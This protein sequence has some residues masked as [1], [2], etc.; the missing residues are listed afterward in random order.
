LAN[1]ALSQI[2]EDGRLMEWSLPFKEAEPG[3][4]HLS[5]LF[6]FHP[7][8]QYNLHDSP[9]MASAVRKS[10]D[11]RLLHGGGHTGWSRA[12]IISFWARLHEP[13]DAYESLLIL[14][15]K[16]TISN[17][18]NT[19]PPFQIDGNFG[20]V[21]GIAEMLVQSHVGESENGYRIQLLPA[22]PSAWQKG[23]VK[24]LRARGGFKV[25][26]EWQDGVF[27]NAIITGLSGGT[28]RVQYGEKVIEL[29]IDKGQKRIV[30]EK[31]FIEQL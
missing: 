29:D 5:H 3:H 2:G 7:G 26:I 9:E 20:A 8:H 10:I 15:R 18:F 27:K 19:H 11:Y 4:R 16:S 22:L 14:L 13:Q 24:G 28:C 23:C 30:T 17:L 31:E 25:D 1:L 6:A 21:A 12:W